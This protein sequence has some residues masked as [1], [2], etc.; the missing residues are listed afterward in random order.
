M[1]SVTCSVE[2]QIEALRKVA[3]NDAVGLIEMKPD[4]FIQGIVGSW[5]GEF[6]TDRARELGFRVERDFDE[7]VQTYVKDDLPHE[8]GSRPG[9]SR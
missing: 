4:P 6:R 1:P 7:I 9:E 2:E 8:S 3:G 5:P